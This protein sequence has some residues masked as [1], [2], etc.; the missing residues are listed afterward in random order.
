MSNFIRATEAAKYIRADLKRAFPE[1]RFSV[2]ASYFSMGSAV[3]VRY[4]DGPPEA[5]VQ[6]ILKRYG[7]RG[8]DGM[9]DSTFYEK[10]V[11]PERRTA[12]FLRVQREQSEAA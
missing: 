10:A 9:D 5:D 12:A 8:F 2:R 4:T 1:T 11:D 7:G 6:A 3:D